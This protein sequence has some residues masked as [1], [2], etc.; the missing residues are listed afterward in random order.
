[1]TSVPKRRSCHSLARPTSMAMATSISSQ[2]KWPNG[3]RA[4]RN[5]I[6]QM[7][8]LDILRQWRG[9]FRLAEFATGIGLSRSA[10]CR[11]GWRQPHGHPR[12]TLQWEAPRVDVW[13]QIGSGKIAFSARPRRRSDRG[14]VSADASRRDQP[15]HDKQRRRSR[16]LE[17]VASELE[18][19]LAEV[20]L[21]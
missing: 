14:R 17:S 15:E 9:H 19:I 7:P 1:M 13:L 16:W 18:Y 3:P 11:S 4:N 12:Q 5:L 20:G 6:I 10:R 21:E 2:P 8:S